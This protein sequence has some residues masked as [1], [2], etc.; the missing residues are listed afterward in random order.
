MVRIEFSVRYRHLPVRLEILGCQFDV[1]RLV[2]R[3]VDKQFGFPKK[4]ILVETV[5]SIALLD[6]QIETRLVAII[7]LREPDAT[8]ILINLQRGPP[9][10]LVSMLSSLLILAFSFWWGRASWDPIVYTSISP[11]VRACTVSIIHS[12]VPGMYVVAP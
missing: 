8:C 9:F 10:S 6:E 2:F 1:H 4:A 7:A 11:R 3:R 12:D 5:K